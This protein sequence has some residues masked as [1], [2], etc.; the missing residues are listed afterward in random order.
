MPRYPRSYFKTTYFHII[1]QGIN[2]NYIFDN[3]KD[4]KYYIK[5]MYELTEDNCVKII[6][7]CIMDNHV[8]IL[9]K[10]EDINNLS[11]YMHRLNTRYGKYYNKKYK[12]VG[13]VFRD[14][15]KSEGIYS[16][17]HLYNC[18]SYIYNNPVKAKICN[19]AKDYQYSNCKKTYNIRNDGYTFIDVI[20][21]DDEDKIEKYLFENEINIK[22]IIKDETKLKQVIKELKRDNGISLRKIA[23]ILKINREKIR[24]LYVK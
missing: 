10:V 23:E 24:K 6:A 1:T 3:N 12:R 15:Y 16:Q 18:I 2:K 7:Y 19:N 22:E 21:E 11:K 14:R 13:Y 20:E 8:H 17:E 4:K 5:S 9:L